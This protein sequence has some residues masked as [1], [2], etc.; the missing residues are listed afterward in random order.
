MKKWAQ[1]FDSMAMRAPG[2]KLRLFRWSPCGAPGQV[3]GATFTRPPCLRRRAGPGTPD[4]VARPRGHTRSQESVW[5]WACSVPRNW[6]W[7]RDAFG[8]RTMRGGVAEHCALFVEQ[9]PIAELAAKG[10]LRRS[11]VANRLLRNPKTSCA[12]PPDG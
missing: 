9:E 1:F 8:E 2:S 6:L 12:P 4:P 5:D 7:S 11:S 3:P 10:P